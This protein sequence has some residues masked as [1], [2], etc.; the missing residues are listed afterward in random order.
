[1]RK[2]YA[3]PLVVA[4]EVVRETMLGTKVSKHTEVPPFTSFTLFGGL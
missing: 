4:S 1:M 2:L 3:V